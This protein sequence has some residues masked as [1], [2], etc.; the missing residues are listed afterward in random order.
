MSG[1]RDSRYLDL[2]GE[3][4]T[5]EQLTDRSITDLDI[6]LESFHTFKSYRRPLMDKV[7]TWAVTG[8]G[9]AK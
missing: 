1:H 5:K 7:T 6:L 4:K 8:Q 9:L 3:Q 2:N